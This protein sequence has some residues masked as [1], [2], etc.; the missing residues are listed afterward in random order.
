[1]IRPILISFLFL[2]LGGNLFASYKDSINRKEVVTRHDIIAHKADTLASITMGNGGFAFTVDITGLQTFYKDYE[3]GVPLGTESEWGWHSFPNIHHYKRS[4]SY[5]YITQNGRQVSYSVQIK[6]PAKDK[7]AVDYFRVNPHR[8]QLGNIGFVLLKKNGQR[9]TLSDI[10]NI[11]QH[12]LLWKGEL[13]SSF[14]LEGTP[15]TVYTYANQQK[16]GISFKV[17][18]NLLK[19]GRLFIRVAFPYPTGDFSD[20]GTYFKDTSSQKS[21]FNYTQKNKGYFV[22]QLDSTVYYL[23]T[24]WN[25]AVDIDSSRPNFFLLE[26]KNTDEFEF[27]GVFSQKK[28]I[29]KDNLAQIKNSNFLSWKNFWE[30]GGAIDFAGSKDKRAFELERRIILSEYLTRVQCAGSFPPQETGL[31]YNSWYGKEHLE[32]F[33]W[34]AAHFALWGHPELLEKSLDWYFKIESKAKALAQRQGYQGVRWPKMVDNSGNESPSSVG[35]FL[36]WEQPHLIYLAEL[37]Y[38]DK[39]QKSIIEKYKHLVFETADFM[40]SFATYDSATG[41]YNLGKGIIPAQECFNATETFNPTYELSYWY[42]ALNMAQK[43]RVRSGL[44]KNKKWENIIKNLAPLPQKDGLY[45]A[46]QSTPDCYAPDS[47]VTVDHPAVLAALASFG[48]ADGLDTSV[49]KRTFFKVKKVWHWDHTW[50]WD[51]PLVAMTATRLHLPDEAVDALFKNVTTNTYLPNGNNYQDS[52]LTIYL[53]GNGGLLSA[54]A[55]MCAGFD[56]NKTPTPGFDRK[57]WKVKWEGLSPL[58]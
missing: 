32:M 53:P 13:I 7:A 5:K 10:K 11:N 25:S 52:R 30:E 18:S 9:A 35:A 23:N 20:K 1:M 56:G 49:M 29:V 39:K 41:K 26:P 14:T 47:K 22:H 19:M 51:F 44:Q 37:L 36:I 8:L 2:T 40:A 17:H 15:V 54:I 48:A 43:W 50:G 28:D 42:W 57:N 38:R 46:T 6:Y 16:D 58:P 24:N 34:H 4:Q 45:L 12:L 27:N 55:L 33:W 31:T 21:F 3:N